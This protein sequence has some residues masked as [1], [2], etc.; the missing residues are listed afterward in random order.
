MMSPYKKLLI[1][2]MAVVISSVILL[3]SSREASAQSK[4]W[5]IPATASSMKNPV[6][7]DPTTLKEAKTLYTSYCSP[8]HGDKGKGDGPAA[9]ALNPKP[10]DHTSAKVQN[11]TDGT[12]FYMISE[13]RDP[14]PSLKRTLTENQRWALVD[15]IRTL[16]KTGKK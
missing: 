12:L 8:C 11:E 3:L 14:M 1:R 13:G 7:I 16:G 4:P 10:A 6:P 9:V 5:V 2:G 15:Y